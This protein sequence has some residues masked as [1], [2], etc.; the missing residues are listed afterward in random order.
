MM[1]ELRVKDLFV[2]SGVLGIM[3]GTM[4]FFLH[5][6]ATGMNVDNLSASLRTGAMAGST[7]IVVILSYTSVRYVERSRRLSD[8]A[9]TVDPVA[10]LQMSLMSI[11]DTASNLPWSNERPW[12]TAS[13]VRVDRGTLTVD[14][15]DLDVPLAQNVVERIIESR[16]WVGRIRIVTGRGLNS[17]GAPKIRPVVIEKLRQVES[18]LDWEMLLKK[19]SLTLRPIGKAPT[20]MRWLL[21][22]IFLGTPITVAFAF[23]FRDLAGEGAHTQGI[24]VG[25][26]LGVLLSGMLASYRERN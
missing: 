6:F 12:T 23:A 8:E 7:A 3:V 14:L 18:Q 16:E 17:K 13:H 25:I 2:L 21:R 4:T 11:E 20:P 1:V 22:F 24:Y 10:R 9:V 15:H 26:G 5:I 19:G